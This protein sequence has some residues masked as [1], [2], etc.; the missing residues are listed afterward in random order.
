[1]LFIY[2]FY[3]KNRTK[4]HKNEHTVKNSQYIKSQ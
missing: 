3:C 1:M 4:V 2:L